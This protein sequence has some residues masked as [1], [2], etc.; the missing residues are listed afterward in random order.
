MEKAALKNLPLG[1][2]DFIDTP[3]TEVHVK[4]VLSKGACNKAPRRYGI[5][6]ESFKF[7]W[8]SINN[9]MLALCNQ[10]YLYDR[11]REKQKNRFLLC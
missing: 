2:R 4:A 10:M 6:L 7:N 8:E 3:N 5:C 9:D 11:I 1:W